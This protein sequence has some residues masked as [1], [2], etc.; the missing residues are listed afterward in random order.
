MK[1]TY[2]E[3]LDRTVYRLRTIHKRYTDIYPLGEQVRWIELS[4]YSTYSLSLSD[5]ASKHFKEDLRERN[6][7]WSFISQW[8]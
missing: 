3:V 8:P 2:S 7:A 1:S 5:N 4:K 6:K